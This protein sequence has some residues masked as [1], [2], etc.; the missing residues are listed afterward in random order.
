M[1]NVVVN[2]DTKVITLTGYVSEKDSFK[3]ISLENLI[4]FV[5]NADA[6]YISGVKVLNDLSL[7]VQYKVMSDSETSDSEKEYLYNNILNVVDSEAYP[8]N[9]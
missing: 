7:P 8:T 4:S 5:L 9:E 1:Q 6:S 2:N 3:Q